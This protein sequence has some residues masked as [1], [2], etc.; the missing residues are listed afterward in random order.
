MRGQTRDLHHSV[1]PITITLPCSVA[2][3][4]FIFFILQRRYEMICIIFFA[5]NLARM[6]LRTRALTRKR[7]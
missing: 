6:T 5:H 2:G 7:I 3:H 1:K 4:I